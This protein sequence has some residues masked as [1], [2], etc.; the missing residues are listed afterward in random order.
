MVKLFDFDGDGHTDIFGTRITAACHLPARPHV[1]LM[2]QCSHVMV[3][4]GVVGNKGAPNIIYFG[5]GTM[6]GFRRDKGKQY[7]VEYQLGNWET[8]SAGIGDFNK[9]G[10]VRMTPPMHTS[11]PSLPNST[12]HPVCQAD[13]YLVNLDDGTPAPN[14]PTRSNEFYW[15]GKREISQS[16][17][18][19]RPQHTLALLPLIPSL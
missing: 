17:M 1:N 10:Y 11:F 16:L 18:A 7:E 19:H 12:P 15:G 13:I 4:C 14:N 6:T 3:Q 8:L 9:D 5:D 2:L